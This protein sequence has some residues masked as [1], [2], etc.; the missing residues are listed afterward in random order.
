MVLKTASLADYILSVVEHKGTEQPYSGEY[1]DF[2][3]AGTYLCRQCGLALFRSQH[4]FN[5][6]CGWPSF[7]EEI[8]DAVERKIDA[9]G[10]RTE[11]ICARCHAHLGHVF[12]G[13]RLTAKSVRHCVN[14][15]SL[16]YVADLTV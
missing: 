11:I 6:A 8:A 1:N 13:E 16:D 7:D 3:E 10:L 14:S 4:K 15:L 9:D 12:S 2:A 5:S